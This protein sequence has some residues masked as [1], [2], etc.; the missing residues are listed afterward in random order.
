MEPQ[1]KSHEKKAPLAISDVRQDYFKLEKPKRSAHV[2]LWIFV[3]FIIVAITWA[4][5]A[6]LD[7]VTTG[8]GKV[9][10][11]RQVQLIQN[12]EGGIVSEILVTEGEIVEKGQVLIIFD[13]TRF[14]ASFSEAR[15]NRIVL[16]FEIARLSAQTEDKPLVISEELQTS[17]PGIY[18]SET[19]LYHSWMNGLDQLRQAFN[20]ADRE[21]QLTK[22]L[23]AK[24]AVSEVEVLRL[25]R[26]I[27]ELQGQIINFRTEALNELN[28]VRAE[29]LALRESN[30]IHADRLHRTKVRSPVRG[31]V[32]QIKVTTIGAI[33]QPGTDLME[34]VPLDD[35]LLIEAKIRPSDIG[36]LHPG[37]KAMVKITAYDFSI[38]GGLEGTLE[39]I[40]AD[41]LEDEQDKDE[42]FYLIRVR[43]TENQ[44]GTAGEP[45]FIIPGMSAT[46]DILTGEKSVLQYFLK[47]ILKAKQNALR[48]R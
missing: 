39:R 10:P 13:D 45:L 26:Q 19:S 11:S 43:T 38:Y 28:E 4:N 37:Q 33:G 7:E 27:N 31:I 29:L 24:G 30:I 48:E 15:Q 40:S 1:D 12:L 41:T 9:I 16:E 25:Q 36:F 23:V 2:I 44:L 6:I 32:N 42:S 17:H 5:F 46:V 21:L 14:S 20:L 34:I 22:P 8:Q 47:P 35:T 18:A 3:A